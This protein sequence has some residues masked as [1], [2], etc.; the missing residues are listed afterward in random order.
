MPLEDYQE[1]ESFTAQEMEH[2]LQMPLSEL[3][4]F[5]ASVPRAGAG[6]YQG[7]GCRALVRKLGRGRLFAD[8][9]ARQAV[10]AEPVI[11]RGPE[12][13]DPDRFLLINESTGE[14]FSVRFSGDLHDYLK[15]NRPVVAEPSPEPT[16]PPEPTEP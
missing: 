9:V 7:D 15:A 11:R 3:V 6:R 4:E 1:R 2:I 13:G 16:P 5:L 10:N 12:T 8:L 14:Q